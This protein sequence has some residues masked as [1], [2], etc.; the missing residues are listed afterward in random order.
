MNAND[1]PSM[2][3]KVATIFMYQQ[4]VTTEVDGRSLMNDDGTRL[5]Y[6]MAYRE[7]KT[8]EMS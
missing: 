2:P 3:M 5:N 8:G 4:C 6:F 7:T 1:S